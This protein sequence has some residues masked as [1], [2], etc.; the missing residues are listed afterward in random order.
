VDGRLESAWP[1]HGSVLVLN[2]EG[3]SGGVV[4]CTAG[5]SSYLD[6]GIHL[7]GLDAASGRKLHESRA[8]AAPNPIGTKGP[9]EEMTPALP[10]VLVSNGTSINMRH[11]RFDRALVRQPASGLDTLVSATG[12]LE[13]CWAHRHNCTLGFQGSIRYGSHNG[14]LR[15]GPANPFGKLVVFDDRCA[16]A[17][18][19]MY[20]F[21][22][23]S[24]GMW[25]PAHRGH[26]HQKYATYKP[27]QF[28]A[29]VRLYAQDN[30]RAAQKEAPGGEK[31]APRR[32]RRPGRR[33]FTSTA[34]H[35]W[36]VRIPLQIRGMVLAGER[37]FAAGWLDSVKIHE[38]ATDAGA[39]FLWVLSAKDGSKLAEYKLDAPP[40]FDGLI[41]AEGKL[42]LAASNGKVA[43][44][45]G[46]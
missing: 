13:D 32:G 8:Y 22:K 35:K 41:A 29:G 34:S 3:G 39:P 38:K 1:V 12:L 11:V 28:P 4:Y 44:W 19:T 17:V 36:S 27:Q 37:I 46:K 45:S 24:P 10:D 23:H 33:P 16:Y 18:Q 40:V 43:C 15:C 21:L 7:Y 25:P 2:G 26:L 5:R 42:Y 31:K 14:A 20:T 6:G 9:G 30:K